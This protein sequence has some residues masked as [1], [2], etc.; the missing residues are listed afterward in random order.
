M[1]SASNFSY[2]SLDLKEFSTESKRM[3]DFIS[4]Y[5]TNIEEYPVKSQVTPGYLASKLP[6]SPPYCPESLEDILKDVKESIIPGLTHWQSP[7]FFAYFQAN[8]STAGFLGEMLCSGL[9]VVGFNWI[10]SPAMTELESIVMDWLG[11]MLK[12][13][14][15]FLFSG[16]GGGVLHGSTCEAIVCTLVA[17]RDRILVKFG[18]DKITKLVVY[19]SDQTHSTLFKGI[20]LIGIPP[21]NFRC[22]PTSSSDDFSLSSQ[23]LR[24]AIEKDVELGFIPVYLCAT[25][26]TTGCGAVDPLKELGEVAREHNLWFHI[27]GAYGG[28]V[29]I[30]PEYRHYL[31][32]VEL[33]DSLSMNPHKWLLSNMDC[34]CLWVKTPTAL[35][36]SLS[37]DAEFLKNEASESKQVID[38]KDWQIALSRRFRSIKLW[39]V[40]RKHGLVNLMR[41]IRS[42]VGMAKRFESLVAEDDRFEV[43]APR[44]FALVCFRLKPPSEGGDGTELNRK[45][46]CRLNQSGRAFMTHAVIGGAFVLRCAIGATLTEERH[47]DELWKLIQETAS[48]IFADDAGSN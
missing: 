25:I 44:R 28:S 24:E 26:G 45:L 14:S 33:A 42:D 35:T 47:I 3:V 19:G 27:D 30:C 46:L 1:G 18:D 40:I 32:G 48:S 17:A 6:D 2:N 4:D 10:S 22:L 16:G 5:Y 41:H 8:V 34:C 20:R 13:P 15:S 31:D 7:N 37:C 39:I 12:L 29:C 23:T 36:Q 43:A 21:S 38:Y 11:K 9:N